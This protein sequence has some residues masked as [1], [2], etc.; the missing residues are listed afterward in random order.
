MMIINEM[1]I[2]LVRQMEVRLFKVIAY[3]LWGILPP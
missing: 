3:I 1:T 2:N